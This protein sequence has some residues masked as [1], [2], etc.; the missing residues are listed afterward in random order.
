VTSLDGIGSAQR[1]QGC[2]KVVW[3]LIAGLILLRVPFLGGIRCL[4]DMETPA[5]VMPGFEISTYLLSAV[6]ILVERDR[7]SDYHIDKVALAIFILGKPLELLLCEYQIPFQWPERSSWYLLYIPIALG[8]LISI[9]ITDPK[10]MKVKASRWQW[11]IG[12]VLVGIALGA[13]FGILVR[14]QMEQVRGHRLTPVLL[15]FLPV[16]QVIYAGIAEEP[17]FRGFLWGALRRAG[18]KEIWIW[19]LQGG[20]FWLAHLYYLGQAPLSFWVIVPVAGLVLGLLVWRSRSVG[21]SMVAHG[22]GNGVGQ[23]IAYYH[24]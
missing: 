9:G 6:L 8:L 3:S 13:F 18:W 19:L 15:I 4:T 5:W 10:L 12:G 11:I 17:L 22:F 7:L 23:I 16:Q 2:D 14:L 1:W 21:A 24:I 20:L